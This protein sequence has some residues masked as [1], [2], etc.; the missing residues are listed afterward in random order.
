[1]SAYISPL[2][3]K[4]N[5]DP[6]DVKPYRPIS[7]L[8]VTSKLLKRLVAKQLVSHLKAHDLLPRIQYVY[9]R[10]HSTETAVA[11]VFSGILT[12]IDRCDVAALALLDLTA[13]FDTVDHKIF[14]QRL[15][16]T[17]HCRI[18]F[19]IR[20]ST[21]FFGVLISTSRSLSRDISANRL[22]DWH[23]PKN[24]TYCISCCLCDVTLAMTCDLDIMIVC[25]NTNLIPL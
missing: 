6:N 10:G 8:S 22:S 23:V 9:R 14:L 15:L 24:A 20:A 19:A 18:W 17:M 16:Q 12:T 21:P 11:K 7:S 4:T 25:L 2:L 13:A 1:M 3:V 5:I